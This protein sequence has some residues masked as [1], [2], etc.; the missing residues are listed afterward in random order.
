MLKKNWTYLYVHFFHKK[1]SSI[2]RNR[3]NRPKHRKGILF[4]ETLS[5]GAHVLN[6]ADNFKAAIIS[7]FKELRATRFKEL[8]YNGNDLLYRK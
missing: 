7:M 3:K 6:L 1:L 8:K 4:I 5:C 2:P